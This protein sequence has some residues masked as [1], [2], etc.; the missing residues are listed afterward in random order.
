MF[1]QYYGQLKGED[2]SEPLDVHV[3]TDTTNKSVADRTAN[4]IVSNEPGDRRNVLDVNK[5]NL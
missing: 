5:L 4:S 1:E 2:D 3:L